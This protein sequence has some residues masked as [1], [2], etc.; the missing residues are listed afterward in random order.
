M[1]TTGLWG[2]ERFAV[3]ILSTNILR[4]LVILNARMLVSTSFSNFPQDGH[5]FEKKSV[6]KN[7]QLSLMAKCTCV[8][9]Y[10]SAQ[11]YAVQ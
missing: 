9:S 3:I 6:C 8:C 4:F 1:A 2:K 5:P 10:A 7:L 11:F